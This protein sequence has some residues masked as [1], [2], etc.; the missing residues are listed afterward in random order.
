MSFSGSNL[1]AR[2]LLVEEFVK[3]G[4]EEES[5][6]STREARW[7]TQ[8]PQILQPPNSLR[9]DHVGDKG[10][11]CSPPTG[12]SPPPPPATAAYNPTNLK[13]ADSRAKQRIALF[14]GPPST[15]QPRRNQIPIAK[16]HEEKN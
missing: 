3:P 13:S 1:V 6:L 7:A 9:S 2:I 4:G 11:G 16:T 10:L 14:S 5:S 8:E 15:S 12:S